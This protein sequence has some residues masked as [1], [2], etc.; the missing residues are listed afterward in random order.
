M[1][2]YMIIAHN[3]FE[4]LEKLILALDDKRNDIFVHI[5]AKVKDFDFKRFSELTEYSRVI[6]TDERV[7]V[8]WGDY[9][10]VKTEYVLFSTAVTHENPEKPYDYFHLISGVDFPIK[11]NDYIHN[12]FEEN[13]GK[14]FV[15]FFDKEL[16]PAYL[17]RVKYYHFFLKKRNLF[18]K[19]LTHSI[20]LIQKICGVNRLKNTDIEIQ[21]GCNWVSVT[22]GFAHYIVE[23]FP[24]YEKFLKHSFCGD[25]IFIQTLLINSPFKDNLY[26]K[27]F[28]NDHIMCMRLI[29]WERGN[30]YIFRSE[31]LKL[32]KNS[33][34]IFARK[35]DLNVDSEIIDNII[36]LRSKTND[37]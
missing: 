19:A 1:H 21:K 10:Q 31:D 14:E 3:Q 22:G 35:F 11:S 26:I 30:P 7:S 16:L 4:L 33:P 5:D 17:N 34:C 9:S 15:H 13:K 27:E 18:T 25:E 28:N 6:F 36:Y 20:V 12:F 24:K 8:H 2:A 37:E 23:E 32:I 29:D